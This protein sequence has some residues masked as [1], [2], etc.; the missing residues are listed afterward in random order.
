MTARA[1]VVLREQ[2][3]EERR[4]LLVEANARAE[5]MHGQATQLVEQI[6]SIE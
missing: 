5:L 4:S 3:L 1:H 6:D 2:A